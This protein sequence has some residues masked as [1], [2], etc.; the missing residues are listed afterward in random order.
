MGKDITSIKPLLLSETSHFSIILG[1]LLKNYLQYI[2]IMLL[3]VSHSLSLALYQ[4]E[5]C[6]KFEPIF[7][8]PSSL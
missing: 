3:C 8:S 4:E 1:C 6:H 5:T 2:V 7:P